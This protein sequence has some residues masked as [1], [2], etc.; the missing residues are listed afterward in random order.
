MILA[1]R[2]A[3]RH[4]VKPFSTFIK[5]T[6]VSPT[7][8]MITFE[9]VGDFLTVKSINFK[10]I[11]KYKLHEPFV[12]ELARVEKIPLVEQN[13]TNKILGKTG[14]GEVHYTIEIY[15]E[16]HRQSFEQNSKI[17]SGQVAKWTV[18]DILGAEP[19]NLNLVEFVKT[20]LLLVE[21]CHKVISSES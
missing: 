16:K 13:N 3:I 20:M 8:Q 6:S 1:T 5:K 11:T 21:R 18:N 19:N 17:K 9:N 4:D 7:N 12:A 2:R 14:Y 15:N 10:Q